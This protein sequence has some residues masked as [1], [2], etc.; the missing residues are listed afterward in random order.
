[1]SV[2][3]E[4]TP[5]G[6]RRVVTGHDTKGR[7]V[8]LS[9]GPTPTVFSNTGLPGLVFHEMW[10]MAAVPT[11]I[12]GVEPE[13]TAHDLLLAPPK[14]GVRIRIND[15]PSEGAHTSAESAQKVFDSLG[16]TGAHSGDSAHAFMHRTETVDFAIVLEGEMLLIVDEGETLVKAG[17]VIVQR[18]TNHA[19]ANRSGKTCRVAFILVGG[20]FVGDLAPKPQGPG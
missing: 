5:V 20:E 16:A 17:D 18:G 15:I 7:A 19:W 1:M 10:E 4:E 13:P 14:S 6:V 2:N 9:D 12:A 11:P 8:I 3:P